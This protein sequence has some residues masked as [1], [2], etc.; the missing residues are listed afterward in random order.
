MTSHEIEYAKAV[1]ES[2][3]QALVNHLGRAP[4]QRERD[5]LAEAIVRHLCERQVKAGTTIDFGAISIALDGLKD[6]AHD[7]VQDYAVRLMASDLDAAEIERRL[8]AYVEDKL[9][10]HVEKTLDEVEQLIEP[11]TATK[12]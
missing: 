10:P 7:A 3:V 9:S 1:A 2:S 6:A 11:F 8:E 4:D 12:H 5:L